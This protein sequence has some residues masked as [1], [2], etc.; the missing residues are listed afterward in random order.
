MIRILLGML[1][2][3]LPASAWAQQ[4]EM[5]ETREADG[6]HTLAHE[7]IVEADAREV[8]AAVSTPEGWRAWA[9]PLAWW[10]PGERGMLETSFVRGAQPGDASTIRHQIIAQLPGRL[11]V[12]RTVKGPA[13][14]PNFEQFRQ[15]TSFIELHSEGE[16]RTRV[17]ATVTGYPDSEG[18]RQLLGFFREGN[19]ISLERLGQSFVTGPRN[20][21]QAR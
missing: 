10:A 21:D 8:W 17:R 5:I 19:R 14:F 3:L 18:G 11:I 13:S 4:V 7:T 12:Y 2:I 20:W 15:T 6:T 1:L 16:G 9:A